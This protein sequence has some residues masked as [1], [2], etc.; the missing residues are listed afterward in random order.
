MLQ[1]KKQLD[2]NKSFFANA[3]KPPPHPKKS[4]FVLFLFFFG[5]FGEKLE[6]SKGIIGIRKSK[7]TRQYKMTK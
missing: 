4:P 7:M 5:L 3:A 6:D 1:T 2:T